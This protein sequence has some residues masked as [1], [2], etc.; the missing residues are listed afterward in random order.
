[1]AAPGRWG[2]IKGKNTFDLAAPGSWGA[3]KGKSTFDLTDPGRWGAFK[4]KNTF[5]FGNGDGQVE[6]GSL[7]SSEINNREV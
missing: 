3:F 7:I 4:G 1:M 5:G 2:V 6:K